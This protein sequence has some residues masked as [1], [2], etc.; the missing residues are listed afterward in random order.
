MLALTINIKGNL[1]FLAHME[2]N[3]NY[4]RGFGSLSGYQMRDGQYLPGKG[5]SPSW[6]P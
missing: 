5:A 2:G 1:L 3:K 4:F 6:L